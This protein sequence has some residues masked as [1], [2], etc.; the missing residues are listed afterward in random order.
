M[1][2][3]ASAYMVYNDYL[4]L[5]AHFENPKFDYIKYKGKIRTKMETFLKRRDLLKK[6]PL[7][8]QELEILK[9][10]CLDIEKIIY[11]QSLRGPDALSGDQ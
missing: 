6:R 7:T 5:I 9:Q 1:N 8:R 3:D 4:A 2:H 11:D 10:W